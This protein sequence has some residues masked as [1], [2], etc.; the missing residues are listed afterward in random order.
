MSSSAQ[1]L[2]MNYNT[3]QHELEELVIARQKL[4]TQLQENKIVQDE[5]DGLREET[6]VYKLTGNVLLPVEQFEAKSNVSKRLEFITA[7]INRCEENIKTK[8]GL[9]EKL[10][11]ELLQTQQARQQ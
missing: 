10:R 5:F 7:E 11:A 4:E 8:Q 6:Q 9:L 3:S 1:D 2:T